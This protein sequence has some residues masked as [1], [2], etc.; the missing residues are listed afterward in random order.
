MVVLQHVKGPQPLY[1]ALKVPADFFGGAAKCSNLGFDQTNP[2]PPQFGGARNL[3]SVGLVSLLGLRPHSQPSPESPGLCGAAPEVQTG[4]GLPGR[5]EGPRV[6]SGAKSQ[7]THAEAEFR[8]E[9]HEG[10]SPSLS[11]LCL[12]FILLFVCLLI[13]GNSPCWGKFKSD[14][15]CWAMLGVS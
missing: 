15:H 2:W 6:A 14:V 13:G 9:K 12:M 11:L 3:R 8:P 4:D 5:G 10:L 7:L 1:R